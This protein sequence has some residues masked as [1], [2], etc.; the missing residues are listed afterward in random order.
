MNTRFAHIFAFAGLV[1][2]G[3]L[4]QAQTYC[5]RPIY[6]N[7]IGTATRPYSNIESAEALTLPF[8]NLNIGAGTYYEQL[9]LDRACTINATSGPVVIGKTGSERTTLKV[10]SFN[11]HLFGSFPLP[12]WQDTDR[13]QALGIY[14]F[15]EREAGLDL[16]GLQEVWSTSR[17]DDIRT[18]SAYPHGGYG[19][20]IDGSG[21]QNSG[22]AIMTP[23]NITNGQQVTYFDERGTDA[24]A[25]KG[26]L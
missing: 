22:L 2:I 26:F 21:T 7:P 25:T 19:G 11:T 4:S 8:T 17:W 24:S 12:V 13:A 16:V 3:G 15:F 14:L 23:Y 1:A 5:Q 6:F 10:L 20:R 18:L 9:T